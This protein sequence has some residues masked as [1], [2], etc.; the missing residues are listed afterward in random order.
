MKEFVDET[1]KFDG[2]GCELLKTEENSVEKGEIARLEQFLLFSY[3]F[4]W[5]C[6]ADK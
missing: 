1:F 3:C 4:K 6:I 5:N 2:S